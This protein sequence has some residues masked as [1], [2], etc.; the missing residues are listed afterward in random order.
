[1]NFM[2]NFVKFHGKMKLNLRHLRLKNTT[3]NYRYINIFI[4]YIGQ[5]L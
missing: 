4:L 1:M 3:V 2:E 5:D